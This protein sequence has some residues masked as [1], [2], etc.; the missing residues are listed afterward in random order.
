MFSAKTILMLM[1]AAVGSGCI[2]FGDPGGSG[3]AGEI[4]LGKGVDP[5]AF[6]TLKIVAVVDTGLPFDPAHPVF[7]GPAPEATFSWPA[8]NED[9]K[10]VTFPHTYL[11][12]EAVGTT[13]VERW[14]L[15]AW[16]SA[17]DE[18]VNV[19]EAGFTSGAEP[20]PLSGEPYGTAALAVDGCGSFG[21]FC[22]VTQG[23][24]ITL[25]QKAP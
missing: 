10:T 2:P 21:G 14:R 20:F 11:S 15:F 23:V 25:D 19:P 7:T 3:A 12:G 18:A 8:S 22:G 13:D 5:S 17:Q 1:M 6:K 9:L 4:S 16:L 24:N